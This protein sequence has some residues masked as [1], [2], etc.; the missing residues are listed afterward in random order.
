M[1][2]VMSQYQ[3]M[4]ITCALI[5]SGNLEFPMQDNTMEFEQLFRLAHIYIYMC[6]C[7]S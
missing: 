6:V 2:P 3:F 1:S 4:D 7:V 5:N